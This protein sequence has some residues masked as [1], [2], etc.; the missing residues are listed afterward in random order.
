MFIGIET[1]NQESLRETKKRQNLKIDLIAEVQRFVDH[2]I[3]VVGGMI[4]GFDLD[5]VDVFRLQYEFAM[6]SAVPIFSL[7]ALV[8]PEGTPLHQRMASEGRLLSGSSEVQ[9][10]PW[11]SNIEPRSMSASEISE[12]LQALS[13]ALY[14][15]KAFGERMLRFIETFGRAR[16]PRA[17]A[18]HSHKAIRKIDAQAVDLAL[19]VRKLGQQESRMLDQVWKATAR[20]PAV[21]PLVT[22]MLFWYFQARHMFRAANYWE[23]RLGEELTMEKDTSNSDRFMFEH[24]LAF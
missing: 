17:A 20:K 4:V 2:G 11:S 19:R 21:A 23:P 18:W 3:S 10:S 13:N 1:P 6:A 15:P 16:K 8:A 12:G 9:G 22:R 5:R 14:A 7:A 24:T